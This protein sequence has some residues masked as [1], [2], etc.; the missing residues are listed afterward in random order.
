[1]Y[2]NVCI[3]ASSK[4][5]KGGGLRWG[6]ATPQLDP[7]GAP[8]GKTNYNWNINNSLGYFKLPEDDPCV[9]QNWFL[10]AKRTTKIRCWNV[11]TI[12]PISR[13]QQVLKEMKQYY[14]D[15]LVPSEVRWTGSRL[16]K[17]NDG[18]TL[19]FSRGPAIHRAGVGAL[20]WSSVSKQWWDGTL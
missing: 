17:L 5:G 8:L 14:S 20:I 12:N 15:T 3:V 16:E 1:M 9:P 7:V 11:R 2:T 10:I 19:A 4:P 18:Y 6:F 13:T